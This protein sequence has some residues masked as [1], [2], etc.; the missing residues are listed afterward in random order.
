[1]CGNAR[2]LLFLIGGRPIKRFNLLIKGTGIRFNTAPPRQLLCESRQWVIA[3][4]LF[5]S[6]ALLAAIAIVDIK[7]L[8]SWELFSEERLDLITDIPV[9]PSSAPKKIERKKIVM[10]NSGVVISYS[11]GQ[12]EPLPGAAA[13]KESGYLV[14][15]AICLLQENAEIVKA[16][17]MKKG[18]ES[19]IWKVKKNVPAYRLKIGPIPDTITRKKVMKAL[20]G[21]DLSPLP[22]VKGGYALTNAMLI[23][24][25]ALKTMEKVE[26]LSVRATLVTERKNA[27]VFKVTSKPFMDDAHAGESLKKWREKNIDGIVEKINS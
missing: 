26:K 27:T 9:A 6:A 19:I 18:V 10:D 7:S 23:K 21:L 24:S 5:L 3:S 1:M 22:F 13:K 2:Q 12:S 25:F 20:G 14:R 4:S 8:I 15:F 16:D 11:S 17:L